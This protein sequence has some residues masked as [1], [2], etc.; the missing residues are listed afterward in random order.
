[1]KKKEKATTTM[2]AMAAVSTIERQS[3]K[4]K[5]IQIKSNKDERRK[6]IWRP[7]Q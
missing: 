7:W 3:N 6:R 2:I 4:E 5:D 1:M